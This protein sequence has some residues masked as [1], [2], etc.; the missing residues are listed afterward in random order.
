M[1]LVTVFDES[2]TQE[3]SRLLLKKGDAT[4]DTVNIE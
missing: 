2:E 4:T 3:L 1:I